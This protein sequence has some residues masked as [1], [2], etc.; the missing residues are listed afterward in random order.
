LLVLLVAWSVRRV[1]KSLFP[2]GDDE[3]D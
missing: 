3:A 2:R 1:R